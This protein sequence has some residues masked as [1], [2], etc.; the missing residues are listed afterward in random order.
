MVTSAAKSKRT[1]VETSELADLQHCVCPED[2]CLQ[3]YSPDLGYFTVE[4]NQ[5]YWHGTG[6]SSLRISRNPTQVICGDEAK[7]TVFIEA[8]N[9]QAG[10]KLFRCPQSD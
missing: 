7:N 2:G 10:V 6:S 8:L 4:E 9:A 5:D 3:N 1:A